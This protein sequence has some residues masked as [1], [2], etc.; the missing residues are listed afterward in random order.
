M[1]WTGKKRLPNE[2]IAHLGMVEKWIRLWGY[3][4]ISRYGVKSLF[5]GLRKGKFVC[6]TSY[7]IYERMNCNKQG[8][9]G[10]VFHGRD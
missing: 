3:L 2:K 1:V 6:Y 4:L 8:K 5:M 10:R 7:Y 9:Y